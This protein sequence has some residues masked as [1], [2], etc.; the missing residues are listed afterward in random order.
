MA[1]TR[2]GSAQPGGVNTISRTP[3]EELGTVAPSLGEQQQTTEPNAF[4][5]LGASSIEDSSL[6]FAPGEYEAIEAEQQAAEEG[7]SEEAALQ[8]QQ[9]RERITPMTQRRQTGSDASWSYDKPKADVSVDGGM[10]K[11]L[12]ALHSNL[13]N[14]ETTTTVP[15][16]RIGK[17]TT[18][19]G[20]NVPNIMGGSE[21]DPMF[22]HTM[23]AVVEQYFADRAAGADPFDKALVPQKTSDVMDETSG[24]ME[25]AIPV[26]ESQIKKSDDPTRLGQEIHREYQRI[27]NAQQGLPTDQ[28][29]DL[30]KEDAAFLGDFA[31]EIYANTMG[32]DRIQR[33]VDPEDG[34]SIV[35]GM[36]AQMIHELDA[37][38]AY[39]SAIMPKKIVRALKAKSTDGKM[40]GELKK[41]TKEHSGKLGEGKITSRMHEEARTNLGSIPNVVDSQRLKILLSTMLPALMSDPS[42]FESNPLLGVFADINNMGPD[43]LKKY[44]GQQA[45]QQMMDEATGARG[46]DGQQKKPYNALEEMDK[47]KRVLAQQLYGIA[48]ERKGA[49][50]LTYGIQSFNGRLS[51]MQ[52]LFNPTTSKA[53]RFVTRNATPSKIVK[54]GKNWN[55]AWQAYAL[56][57]GQGIDMYEP[58]TRLAAMEAQAPKL[59]AWGQRLKEVMN[60]TMT[61]AE[62]EAIADA[63]ANGIPAND[64]KFPKI[65]QMALDPQA[66][67]ELIRAIKKKGEDGPAFID[68]LID[69]AN[70]RANIRRG[71]PHHSY[72]NPTIDGK[73]NGIA[74]N[75]IQMGD[76]KGAIRTGVLRSE[77]SPYALEHDMDIRDELESVL[78]DSS[79]DGFVGHM[80]PEDKAV[81][82]EVMKAAFTT[83]DLNKKIT[84]T[85]GYGKEID[86]FKTEIL[87]ALF[88][89]GDKTIKGHLDYINNHD[90]LTMDEVVSSIMMMYI[91][92]IEQVMSP[93]GIESR[94][95]MWG[96]AFMHAMADE[97]FEIEGP[98]GYMLR[99]GG[100][101]SD[102]ELTQRVGQYKINGRT[103]T[104]VTYG[105]RATSAARKKLKGG[106]YD[107]GGRA[108]GGAVPGPVQAIDAA[109]VV[110]TMSGKSWQKL[111]QATGGNPYVHQVYD[112]FKFDINSFEVGL[113]EVNRNWADTAFKWSYL[114]EAE[115]AFDNAVKAFSAKVKALPEGPVDLNQ[116]PFIKHML[117]PGGKTGTWPTNLHRK[118]KGL[119]PPGTAD[120]GT[121]A[122]DT[123]AL[124]MNKLKIKGGQ[125]TM[126]KQQLEYFYKYIMSATKI[127]T[128][129]GNLKY[130]TD[131]KKAKLRKIV[132]DPRNQIMQ[133]W[134][135]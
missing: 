106:G 96:T 90:K 84:M 18:T 11:R 117:N 78:L 73:T 15:S 24:M 107:V 53:V 25:E 41:Y 21:I 56:V 102:P 125:E 46:P 7:I 120:R 118:L 95:V 109:T 9:E 74:S 98:T 119:A 42:T 51:P 34:K 67:A 128:R 86:S 49:N 39:R 37:A 79:A 40:Q 17:I 63:I 115:V 12:N 44:Q 135:H 54:G 104:A 88:E 26:P 103:L 71:V 85:F 123:T 94:H 52:S 99:Y 68:G 132:M 23:G 91:P 3:T 64:P 77:N 87:N 32:P 129:L 108:W 110:R 70:F 72:I 80:D 81:V 30:E 126:T 83:R 19:M 60:N 122:M 75:A 4:D 121:W 100:N 89:N 22:T 112:A 14:P 105:N 97:L 36:T 76:R 131:N 127:R 47:L 111:K 50:Y 27:R 116:F 2:T 134:A 20:A 133:Y 28:Y 82:L 55:A 43:K 8:E 31:K 93:D 35:F 6:T 10:G 48:Q 1:F 66:D 13:T 61:D 124:I 65:K 69:F 38:K 101:E 33:F 45:L 16:S 113:A 5:D 59:E 62:A 57:I 58:K 114:G 92:A 130:K 29:T